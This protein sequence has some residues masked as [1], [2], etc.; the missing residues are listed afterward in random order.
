MVFPKL[1]PDICHSIVQFPLHLPTAMSNAG[2]SDWTLNDC[3]VGDCS[4]QLELKAVICL[5]L[6][7]PNLARA[8]FPS[9]FQ[10]TVFSHLDWLVCDVTCICVGVVHLALCQKC[11][12]SCVCSG[13]CV[14]YRGLWTGRWVYFI[15]QVNFA[16]L[17]CNKEPAC[18]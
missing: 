1:A 15:L 9:F 16:C 18:L 13:H 4:I 5:S 6:R 11:K 17:L 12:L 10:V 3:Y 8:S 14:H 7:G 2:C